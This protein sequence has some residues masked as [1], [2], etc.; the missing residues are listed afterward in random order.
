MRMEAL[1]YVL[2]VEKRGR[3]APREMML[4]CLAW[5]VSVSEMVGCKQDGWLWTD[6]ITS[7]P[8]HGLR[9]KRLY[10]PRY[11]MKKSQN[12]W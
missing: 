6:V 7:G 3:G 12:V 11:E 2:A 1:K 5:R 9:R 4:D 8:R 10:R